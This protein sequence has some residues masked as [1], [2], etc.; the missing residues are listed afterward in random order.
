MFSL[1]MLLVVVAISAVCIAGMAYRTAWWEASVLTLTYLIFAAAICA[2][3]LC[4]DHR[5]LFVAY[6]TF[7][8]GYSVALYFQL[9]LVTSRG[10]DALAERFVYPVLTPARRF[11]SYSQSTDESVEELIER[12]LKTLDQTSSH[13]SSATVDSFDDVV[14]R[15][16]RL[17]H[18]FFAVLIGLVAGASA[19]AVNEAAYGRVVAECDKRFLTPFSS[20]RCRGC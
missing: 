19:E 15:M 17:G 13:D 6:G 3:I 1:R 18:A 8:L 12:T 16:K 14:A 10:L 4:S 11:D 20:L 7:G 2:A 5:A 9:E